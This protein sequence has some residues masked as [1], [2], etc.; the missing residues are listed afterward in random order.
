MLAQ[1]LIRTL[2]AGAILAAPAPAY[3]AAA[4]AG[5]MAAVHQFVDGF[6]S[7]NTKR[8]VAACAQNAAIVDDF[9]PHQWQSCADWARDLDAAS[10]AA[11]ITNGVVTLGKPWHVAVTG[12]RAYVVVP[13]TYT[14]KQH[15]KPVTESGSI[16][17]LVLKKGAAGWR[18]TSWAWAQH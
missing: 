3:A 1:R 10:K 13:A 8:A 16:F 15:G 18:I 14:Y 4:D 11:G 17:T 9:P 12:D 2:L 5:V 7:G 6:N